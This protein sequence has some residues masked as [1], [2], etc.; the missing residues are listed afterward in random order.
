MTYLALADF[1][2]IVPGGRE[3]WT[4]DHFVETG[5]PAYGAGG[6]NGFL[7]EFEF[8]SPAVVLSSI[9]ARC[10]KCFFPEGPWS[11]LA[12]TQLI[13]PEPERADA[14]FLWFQLN[15]ENRWH[16]SGTAQ[17]FIKTSDIKKHVVY[18]PPLEEQKRIAGI[19]DAADQLRTK[20]QQGIEELDNLTQAIFHRMFGGSVNEANGSEQLPLKE[21]TLKIG[22]GATPRGGQQAYKT[23]GIS[24]IRSMN[25]RDGSFDKTGLAFIDDVQ[26]AKLANVQVEPGDVLLNITGAS[27][28]RVCQVLSSVLPARVNQ[29]VAIIRADQRLEPAFLEAQLLTPRMKQLLL[30]L[31]GQ[32]ATREAITKTAIENLEIYVPP[33]N[34]QL[35]FCAAIES[36]GTHRE[37]CTTALKLSD[38]LFNSL[39]Q[40]AFRGEL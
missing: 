1:C 24:L 10:G 9:G 15:D 14:R 7:P 2:R 22:S 30:N 20:R 27:V 39:Q 33:L 12:N 32:G 13:F 18:L 31:A 11:S 16:R 34:Q 35:R 5:Y 25:V 6:L 38:Q 8:D 23:S 29:H 19:L 4:G 36:L 37:N 21:V 26:A 17:P 28:A 40:R 3:K